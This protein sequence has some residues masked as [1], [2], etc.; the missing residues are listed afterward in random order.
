M[1]AERAALSRHRLAFLPAPD[2]LEFQNNPDLYL[3]DVMYADVVDLRVVTVPLRF[4][5]DA[6]A[7]VAKSVDHPASHLT[8]GQYSGCRIP[9][10]AGLTPYLFFEF[11][12]RS[13]YNTALSSVSAALPVQAQ[14]FSACITDDE[15]RLVHL[16]I[17]A[18]G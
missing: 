2:L 17:P 5:Y 18:K 13:F 9:A 10:T 1:Q 3:E 12:L 6:R 14:R 11:V 15:R 4:D 7:G 16:G 8:L